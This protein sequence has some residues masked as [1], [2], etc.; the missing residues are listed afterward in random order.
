MQNGV[1]VNASY[2]GVHAHIQK[3]I[4]QYGCAI[5]ASFFDPQV[6]IFICQNI[7]GVVGFKR[8]S[9]IAVSM[10]PPLCASNDISRLTAAY[11]MFCNK[12]NMSRIYMAATGMFLNFARSEKYGL[13]ETGREQIVNV[14]TFIVSKSLASYCRKAYNAGVKI[15]ELIAPESDDKSVVDQSWFA[16]MQHQLTILANKAIE[17]RK[18][19]QVYTCDVQ[20]F[21]A[22]AIMR[23]FYA[24]QTIDHQNPQPVGLLVLLKT[25]YRQYAIDNCLQI[26]KVGDTPV[27]RNVTHALIVHM[28]KHINADFVFFHVTE[29][30]KLGEIIGFS[31]S[32]ERIIR[33]GY[34]SFDKLLHSN[35]K[36]VFRDRYAKE[37]TP[38]Y[39]VFDLP[40]LDMAHALAP[41]QAVHVSRKKIL[42]L[43]FDRVRRSSSFYQA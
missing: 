24:T 41:M 4:S 42:S 1:A 7:D 25:G 31:R 33:W 12:N 10:G 11:Q 30:E 43:L 6:N 14:N 26:D 37:A 39:I 18:G 19:T 9:G 2:P 17:K 29:I 13:I 8:L 3:L 40:K 20:P 23:W 15:Y 21:A 35:G 36:Q 28:L 32:Q 5:H 27:N 38:S 22:P 16:S 34:K